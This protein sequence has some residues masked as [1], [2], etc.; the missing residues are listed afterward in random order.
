MGRSGGGGK[1]ADN[2][3]TPCGLGGDPGGG[4]QNGFVSLT[5]TELTTTVTTTVTKTTT[6]AT[7]ATTT[8]ATTTTTTTTDTFKQHVGSRLKDLEALLHSGAE[9]FATP[10]ELEVVVDVLSTLEATVLQHKSDADAALVAATLTL[11]VHEEAING[12]MGSIAAATSKLAALEPALADIEELKELPVYT[13]AEVNAK[14][15]AIRA[16]MEEQQ[17]ASYETMKQF[18]EAFEAKVVPECLQA[19][20]ENAT[21]S[22]DRRQRDVDACRAL[23]AGESN[24]GAEGANVSAAP[25]RSPAADKASDANSNGKQGGGSDGGGTA[26]ETG[27][28]AG[29]VGGI[30]GSAAT[31]LHD[32]GNDADVPMDVSGSGGGGGGGGSS[33]TVGIAVGASGAVV[34]LLIGVGV[35]VAATRKGQQPSQGSGGTSS[36]ENPVYGLGNETGVRKASNPMYDGDGDVGYLQITDSIN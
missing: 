31:G 3:V 32:V 2:S 33:S 28:A 11:D 17:I 10:E 4:A 25:P 18:V 20:T 9:S 6:S 24:T 14:I 34:L 19:A 23:V 15:E 7:T 21:G 8:S 30:G 29:N 26:N 12:N 13:Q 1:C 5:Y 16:E 22:G 36:F 35:G 27:S